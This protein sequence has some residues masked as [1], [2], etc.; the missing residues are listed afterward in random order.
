[1]KTLGGGG[2]VL[3]RQFLG[4]LLYAFGVRPGAWDMDACQRQ[5]EA[6]VALP[7]ERP[8]V[9]LVLN[10]AGGRIVSR[11]DVAATAYL[12]HRLGIDDDGGVRFVNA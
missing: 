5:L 3:G 10:F 2:P 4:N 6:S 1:M 8:R 9:L 7:H 11:D 12:F